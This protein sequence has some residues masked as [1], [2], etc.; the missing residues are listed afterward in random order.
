MGRPR[1]TPSNLGGDPRGDTGAPAM[2]SFFHET[3]LGA[4]RNA[5]VP[6]DAIEPQ[7]TPAGERKG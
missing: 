2:S 6:D 7:L 5:G 4:L 1:R 3:S